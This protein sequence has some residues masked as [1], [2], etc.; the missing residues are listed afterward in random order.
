M[1]WFKKLMCFLDA[2]MT[3]FIVLNACTEASH[4]IGSSSGEVVEDL[5]SFGKLLIGRQLK[6]FNNGV[7]KSGQMDENQSY[8]QER[9]HL[10][11]TKLQRLG[12]SVRCGNNSITLRIPGS[13]TPNLLVDRGDDSPVSLSEVPASCGFSLKRVRRD[14]SLVAP[15]KGCYVQQQEGNYVLPLIILGAP[16]QA[17]CPSAQVPQDPVPIPQVFDPLQPGIPWWYPPYFTQAPPTEPPATPAPQ[18]FDP[19][20]GRPWWFPPYFPQAPPTEPPTTAPPQIPQLK[21]P[22]GVPQMFDSLSGRP[23]WYTAYF[24]PA[25]PTEPPTTPAPQDPIPQYMYPIFNPYQSSLYPKNVPLGPPPQQ[26][27]NPAVLYPPKVVQQ[28]PQ[29]P[30]FIP[31]GEDSPVS[32]SEV[33]ASCGFSLKRVRRDVSLVAPYKGCYVQQQEGNYVLPLI[34]LGAPVQASCPSAQVPQDPVPIPQV[35]DPLQPGIP[36]WYPPYFTQAPSTDPPA[37]AV[38]VPQLQD[39]FGVPQ[40][41]DPISGRPWWFPRYF[42]QAPP[43][44]PPATPAPQVPQLQDPFGVPQTFDPLSG[45]PWWFPPYFPQAPPTDPPATP[46]PQVPQVQD[47]FGVPQMFD[48]LS[49]RPWWYTA[50]FTQ[51]PPTEPPA[52][53]PQ[54][55]IPQY[56]Y[57]MFNPYQSSLYPKNVPL[58]PPPQ[59]SQNPAAL[60][61]PKV[62]QQYPQ[63]PLFI[64][65]AS[66]A[67]P[68]IGG[69]I[70]CWFIGLSYSSSGVGVFPQA[71]DSNG[72]ASEDT[73]SFGKIVI[74]G[75]SVVSEN[76]ESAEPSDQNQ[77]N[78]EGR[79]DSP[80]SLSEVPASC[81]FSLKRVRR[82]VSL[83]APYKGCYVQQQEGS[84]VLPLII[85]GAPVQASCP[86]AQVPQ[87]PVPIPQVFDP[88]QPG[89]P[90][91]YP[92]YFTQAPSTDPPATAVQV[93]QLQDP[94]GV[95]QTYDPLSGR[96]WWFPPYFP[97]APA[98]EPPA[99]AA[100]QVPQL[101]DPFGVPQTFDPLSGRPWWF[102]PYFPQA[103]PTEPP[104]TAAPQ[105]PQLQDPF[106]VPQMFDPLSGRPW[107]YT[108]YFTQAPPTEP[109]TTAPPQ[110]PQLKDPFGVPQMFD[111]LSGRPWWYT[112][113]FTPAPPTEPPT[114]PAP[115]DPIPQYMY[116]MFN[117]YYSSLYTK[118]VPLAS[119]PQ[120]SQNPV[121]AVQYPLKVQQYPQGPLFVPPGLS[122]SSSGVGVFP[123][124]GDSNGVASEDTMSFGKIVIGGE[125]SPVSLSEVPASCG[126]SL[127]RVRRDVSLVAPYKGCYVQQQEGNYVL[128]LIILGAP[129]QASCPS[130]QVPQ[131]PVPIPQV[132]DPL[133][134][135]IPWWYPPYFTQAPSTDPPAT[136]VQVPQL[137]D[138]FGVP[139]TFDPI[140][141]RPWW[142]PRYF[143]QAPPTDPP[144]T[145]APQVP[146]LQDPFGVPQTFDPLSGRPWW[147]P[148]Y[149]PQAPPTDPPATPAPQVPQVQDPFGV[150]QMFDPLSGRPWWYTAYF[151]QAPPT[152]PPAT[153]PQIPQ[154]KDPFGVPQMFDSL[155]GRPW[156]YTAY[157]TPAP[158]TEPPTTPVPQDPIPQYMYPMFNPYYSSLYT[159]NVPL[160]PPPQQ[161][162]NPVPAVQY[163][164]K[165]V[166]QYPQGPLFVPPERFQLAKS[167]LHR[168][169]PSVRCGNDS[170]TLQ[171]PGSR[172]P[173]LLVDRGEDTP[174][175]LSDMP[176]SCGFSLKRVRRDVSLVA[177]YKGCY[178]QQ[179]EGNYVLPLIILGAPVQASCPAATAPPSPVPQDPMP[180]P[181]VF[182]PLQPGI[183]WWY[184][185]Y[186]TQAPPTEPPATPAP[187]V[188]QLQ[189]PFGVPQMF[190]PLSARPWWFPPYF[191]QAPPT[192]PPATAVQVPQL[193]DPFAVPQM[194]DPLSGRPWWY[195]AYFTQAP[196]TEPPATAPQIPQLKDP[197]GVPQNFD[198]SGRPW[199]YTAYFTPAPPTEPPTTPAPQD[200]VPQF[201]YPMFNPYYASLNPKN[202][203]VASPPQQSQNPA[204]QYPLKIVQQYPQGPILFPPGSASLSTSPEIFPKVSNGVTVKEP[205]RVGKLLIG[206][207]SIASDNEMVTSSG[208]N[209]SDEGEGFRLAKAK[210]QRLGPSV[211]CGNDSMT[212]KIP[213]SR[214]PHLLVDRGEDTPVSLSELPASCGFSLK[215]VRRD[216]SLVAPYTGCNVRE[217]DGRYVLP[218]IIL[219]APVQ[220]TCP[221]DPLLSL[222]T[223]APSPQDPV[224]VPQIF[225]P[226]QP[227]LPWW[228]Y[229]YFTQAPPTEPPTT[230][231]PQD[232][233][234]QYVY[235]MFNPYYYYPNS[236]PG[237]SQFVKDPQQSWYL[238]YLQYIYGQQTQLEPLT[239]APPTEAPQDP[240][241]QYM[242]NPYYYYLN[243]AS[244]LGQDQQQWYLAY[245]Q[246]MNSLQTP[247][248]PPTP[249][250]T[251][252]APQDP[253]SQYMYPM[254]NPY[255]YYLN[256]ASPLGQDQQQWYLA[257][258]QYMNSL[259][260]PL[261]PPTPEPTTAA[262]QDPISQYMYPMYNPYYYYLNKA[263]PLGQD[264]QQWYLTYLQY[265]N[266]LQTPLEPPTPEP[267]TAAPQD[268]ISQYMYPMFNPYYYYLNKASP[269]GQDQQQWYLNYLQY[270][271][272]LQ[273]PLE[274]P[275][276][277]PTTAAPQDPIPQYMYPM[278]NP[279]YYYIK[280]AP[281]TSSPQQDQQPWYFQYP[282]YMY[283]YY[284]PAEPTVPA[285]TTSAPVMAGQLP[286]YP[287]FYGPQPIK[288]VISVGLQYPVKSQDPENPNSAPGCLD[289]TG[290]RYVLPLIILGAPV[291]MSC[292]VSSR[293]PTVTCFSSSM[294]VSL[295]VRAEAVSVKGSWEPLIHASSKCSLTLETTGGS[296]VLTAP[297]E[298]SCWD[299]KDS[300]RHL[301]LLYGNQ[302]VTLSCPDMTP[303]IPPPAE[304]Q[305]LEEPVGIPQ[306]SEPLTYANPW[307]Y[308][309]YPPPPEAQTIPT[310]LPA[311]LQDIMQYLD[312]RFSP[313]LSYPK[314]STISSPALPQL[315]GP[316]FSRYQGVPSPAET[317]TNAAPLSDPMPQYLNPMINP[318]SL[319]SKDVTASSPVLPQFLTPW[320]SKFPPFNNVENPAE[321]TTTPVAPFPDPIPPYLNPMFYPPSF[322]PKDG[323]TTSPTLQQLL[324][325]WFPKLPTVHGGQNPAESTNTADPVPPYLNPMFYPL[326]FYPKDGSAASQTPQ[327]LLGHW[328]SKFPTV[329]G[330]KNS[331]D[332]TNTA[333]SVPQ[334][335]NPMFYPLSFYPK[336]GST[337]SQTPQQLLEHWLSKFPTVTGDQNPEEPTNTGDPVPPYMNPMFYPP[338]FYPKDGSTASQTP[339]QL[340]G[341]WLSKL[342]T[343]P[344]D[345]NPEEP[346]NTGDP[347]PPYMNPMFYPPSFYPKD[348]S[349]ASQTPQQLLGHWLSKFPTVTGD[350][351]PE[352]PTNTGDPIPPYLNPMFYPLSFYPNDGSTASQTPQQ[353]LGQWLSK[354]PT[355]PGV[356]NPD[357][358]NPVEP[359]APP[360]TPAELQDSAQQYLYPMF[361]PY[362]DADS[363]AS[364]PQLKQPLQPKFSSYMSFYSPVE[365]ITPAET[366]S[367]G[368]HQSGFHDQQHKSFKLSGQKFPFMPQPPKDSNSV[369]QSINSVPS[370]LTSKR[371]RRRLKQR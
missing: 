54:D 209:L 236:A 136:A 31:P 328:L 338:S 368:D 222:P 283:G 146:Q 370:L 234:P 121:P 75:K 282:S 248:E 212:L 300:E 118:N 289:S 6:A 174:M 152:E 153:A 170:M 369:P 102:P 179:Q 128:P 17:S 353:L 88:L 295:G 306:V 278:F 321:P 108:A 326:S 105:I 361:N 72:V 259:Q 298:G 281:D 30:L 354:L 124:A 51:A 140:S 274:P 109:P 120:Q 312:P 221:T 34:I 167:K 154:L 305:Q 187:Q 358:Q 200:P 73:M 320:F 240:V 38:Q 280:G 331:A 173:H 256:K 131:D 246:Y 165:V 311:Q 91:W 309:P 217:Q 104:A 64:P 189:D 14:V 237:A 133:Q 260:T 32:L 161:S 364:P 176:A 215:R 90:W 166:Q 119:P 33:P 291:Q 214:T 192:E 129:V 303:T 99:T 203:P 89:I 265:M 20:S 365:P 21:D 244:P 254:Y 74:G 4:E 276:P 67:M 142:F 346:T 335:L 334:Y 144:V 45:R 350:Q 114:T 329:P 3:A 15:Y 159:K 243:K 148:P 264:Q 249:E 158:P 11:K 95:P 242:Y 127:K 272:S 117:P 181:Q 344:G 26:S 190:D 9:F 219:G 261:E 267:T 70:L 322:Y 177:P 340:L 253:I 130:A 47:P 56:M 116:P 55:P 126:F 98:T 223:A 164:P 85:L 367:Q 171:I 25:P 65:P 197:F 342:P 52:T 49:G 213:G 134:P 269:L 71:G 145:P 168:L 76:V 343:V 28:Y 191:P 12:P 5:F 316:W 39:P 318:Y 132:F 359:T 228:F 319:Y 257:Y 366:M 241:P 147:F 360:T 36:W 172:T 2:L 294:S 226:L 220:V 162:Q 78:K 60:Y 307:W 292:P 94:F 40:T 24:T 341:H 42:P 101:Q 247:L 43:T 184:P 299:I 58:G 255:Y 351:N 163:P 231:A 27:Q 80:V 204:A 7:Y 106:G 193:Q 268:P 286:M 93:P 182:D 308:P 178:V 273:T 310:S 8:E 186:F 211:R 216:L 68:W 115:Q 332:Q 202:I 18:M 238:K 77:S 141:G 44:E 232:Q 233:I 339:Q 250:P 23:W 230:A 122:Y 355:V 92:P 107:W 138:P 205:F 304:I 224:G 206:A 363:T 352:E 275:T 123:Q 245:L 57:P 37:T 327:Q 208:Q 336:D 46:A 113:Y 284:P 324:G 290:G 227:G 125:D 50:Y 111:S 218:L 348:G 156:W 333:D 279:Y 59:Q 48:P 16:V 10:A 195:T 69:F 252:A 175:S 288:S 277:E 198:M 61:P 157:F 347:V 345:Q 169:G 314:D 139:Q 96:P 325:H 235:P 251:T 185:P 210:L 357:Y 84:Y 266:S 35:F 296:L 29:G 83:V 41:F 151:T 188:P 225:D 362:T 180:V 263:S 183:P 313:Y 293:L 103:P 13:R 196:P 337:A 97:Q 160:A 371:S 137:Q 155:S 302:E 258:L 356:Q 63:G 297:F 1:P 317:V 150:P 285:T 194:F 330:D 22:F 86:S 135:G 207:K 229:P 82:D 262:P 81:G 239:S 79:E 87:D 100:P 271:N 149:F 143:P 62:M 270:M 301:P 315:L 323:S 19:L 112:A 110:I 287:V 201:M 66:V 199:W 53:A 349:T